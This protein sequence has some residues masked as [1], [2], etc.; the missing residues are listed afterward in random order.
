MKVLTDSSMKPNLS[1]ML[2]S[3]Q[4]VELSA[5]VSI[6]QTPMQVALPIQSRFQIPG[7]F[8]TPYVSIPTVVQVRTCNACKMTPRVEDIHNVGLECSQAL[9]Y[10]IHHS[11]VVTLS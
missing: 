7:S 5:H 3:G 9:S 2:A 11:G 10:S 4:H 8:G 1:P 6:G